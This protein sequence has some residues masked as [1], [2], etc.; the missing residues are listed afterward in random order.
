[1]VR[2]TTSC[3][4]PFLFVLKD[5]TFVIGAPILIL[6]FIYLD[7]PPLVFQCDIAA[8]T[9]S[10]PCSNVVF[11]CNVYTEELIHQSLTVHL[12]RGLSVGLMKSN[13]VSNQVMLSYIFTDVFSPVFKINFHVYFCLLNETFRTTPQLSLSGRAA[14]VLLHFPLPWTPWLLC[15][16][17]TQVAT[18]SLS[19]SLLGRLCLMSPWQ[20]LGL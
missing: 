11:S 19:L 16:V 4:S 2:R 18:L 14:A 5:K 10:P 13:F 8:A 1:M 12:H 20:V 17:G 15:T 3:V 9:S 7:L 6:C